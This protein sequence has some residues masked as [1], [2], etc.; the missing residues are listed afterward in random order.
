MALTYIIFRR[1][2]RSRSSYKILESICDGN[3]TCNS[4]ANGQQTQVCIPQLL[5]PCNFALSPSSSLMTS[6]RR[7][8]QSPQQHNGNRSNNGRDHKQ[9]R[10]NRL[11]ESHCIH[12]RLICQRELSLMSID[13]VDKDESSN[14]SNDKHPVQDICL[15]VSLQHKAWQYP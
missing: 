11:L 1:N 2:T 3:G 15:P 5:T 9:P 13:F 8:N 14:E 4:Q 12:E 6:Q 7:N 10:W